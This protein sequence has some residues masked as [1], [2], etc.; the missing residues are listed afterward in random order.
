[1]DGASRTV[2]GLYPGVS[3][4]GGGIL[5]AGGGNG[6]L[7]AVYTAKYGETEW[8]IVEP[9][10]VHTVQGCTAEYIDGFWG[11]KLDL[12]A[13][14]VRYHTLVHS[15]MMEH[16]Y[17]LEAFMLQNRRVL[18]EGQRMVF[19]VP[20]LREWVKR[21]YSNA[22]NFEHTYLISEEYVDLLLQAYGFQVIGKRRFREDHSIFRA[23]EKRSMPAPEGAVSMYAEGQYEANK[24]LFTDYIGYYKATVREMNRK[25]AKTGGNV[26]LFGAHIFSQMLINFG[27]DI[28]GIACILDNDVFKQG[29]RL[30][31]TSLS[32]ASPVLL[33]DVEKPIV[34]LKAGAYTDEIKN[35][36]LTGINGNT[37][38]WI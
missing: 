10:G 8:T 21:K 12:A 6:I 23:A 18:K 15:H 37:E 11:N 35:D 9:A 26:Y 22:L 32:V 31:G 29:K 28:S 20:D 16:Q 30:Y 3:E 25:L 19:S 7:N 36:I 4:P 2:C 27:L 34:I 5:E 14:P 33:R 38:F 17:D 13:H 24:S 1:M